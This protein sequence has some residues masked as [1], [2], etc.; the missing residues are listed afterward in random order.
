M[1]RGVTF[2]VNQNTT[3][4]SPT[5]NWTSHSGNPYSGT[6]IPTNWQRTVSPQSYG[7]EDLNKST[8]SVSH[9]PQTNNTT[10]S[11]LSPSSSTT[12]SASTRFTSYSTTPDYSDSNTFSTLPANTP[13]RSL[14]IW[15]ILTL[16]ALGAILVVGALLIAN[17]CCKFLVCKIKNDYSTD[18]HRRRNRNADRSQQEPDNQH[19]NMPHR[20]CRLTS[21]ITS[22]TSFGAESSVEL[23]ELPRHHPSIQSEDEDEDED[24]I[25]SSE[26]NCSIIITRRS[27]YLEN[28]NAIVNRNSNDPPPYD[29]TLTAVLPPQVEDGRNESRQR[30]ITSGLPTYDSLKHHK[31]PCYEDI[32]Q[33]ESSSST[34]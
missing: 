24:S 6:F 13:I 18:N 34:L 1:A 32:V 23:H 22:T 7:L 33:S 15:L 28:I 11:T 10:K 3:T 29:T 26:S 31:L 14:L 27:I 25:I 30:T 9:S 17:G 4:V 5:V 19:H 8:K 2:T 20:T 21:N 12:L 16:F